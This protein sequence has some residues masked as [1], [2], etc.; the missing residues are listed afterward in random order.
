[1]KFVKPCP[2]SKI[3]GMAVRKQAR[4]VKK[5]TVA[6]ILREAYRIHI[7]DRSTRAAVKRCLG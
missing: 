2:P 3:I 7:R 1:M 6:G 5:S 4:R